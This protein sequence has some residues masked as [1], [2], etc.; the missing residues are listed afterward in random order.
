MKKN[1]LAVATALALSS[2]IYAADENYEIYTSNSEDIELT[3]NEIK[4]LDLSK[5]IQNR[6][7]VAPSEAQNGYV[8]YVYGAQKPS[9]VCSPMQVCDIKLQ[10]GEVTQQIFLGDSSRWTIEPAIEGDGGYSTEHL[11]IKPLDVNIKT[12]LI[13]TTDRRIY[14]INLVSTKNEFMPQVS[15]VYP[16]EAMAKFK[17]KQQSKQQAY[18]A[19]VIPETGEYLDN[20]N[21]DYLIEGDDV[22]WKPIRVYNDGVKTIIEMPKTMNSNEAPA[23]VVTKFNANSKSNEQLVNYRLQHN[24][25][26]V[27]AIFYEAELIAGIGSSQDKVII[28]KAAK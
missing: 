27:D 12:N 17:A 25:F 28:R 14:H 13:V 23:L 16:E 1:L 22:V 21:F 26:I 4:A 5:Q 3:E 24:R 8:Q 11:I 15:F 6:N 20:L 19:K 18:A 2:S 10:Q 9:V 7:T